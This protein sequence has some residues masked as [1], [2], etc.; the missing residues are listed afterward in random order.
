MER[1]I[2]PRSLEEQHEDM[3]ARTG[4]KSWLKMMEESATNPVYRQTKLQEYK[5]T[6]AALENLAL[7]NA[8]AE[9]N[10]I[11]GQGSEE[12]KVPAGPVNNRQ[13]WEMS[14][15]KAPD[16]HSQ[17]LAAL[18]KNQGALY[19][20]AVKVQ[21]APQPAPKKP[22]EQPLEKRKCRDCGVV[23]PTIKERSKHYKVEHEIKKESA[24]SSD[25]KT[26]VK[27]DKTGHF[28]GKSSG[29]TK[30]KQSK[31]ASKSKAKANQS[32]E[33]AECLSK[34]ASLMEKFSIASESMLK[35]MAGPTSATARN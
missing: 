9:T 23:F 7:R 30:S 28:L 8:M 29:P 2:Y 32:T 6:V 10:V 31:K 19:Q 34:M 35:A 16:E 17:R 18:E 3:L 11:Q 15:D 22:E 24:W 14:V 21:S 4:T 5:A 25:F 26:T 20:A 1:E 12:I 33:V 27:T 13:F